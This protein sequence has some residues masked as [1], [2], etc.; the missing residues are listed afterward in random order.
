MRAGDQS[1]DLLGRRSNRRVGCGRC[2]CGL[3]FGCLGVGWFRLRS[4][5]HCRG[6]LFRDD[7]CCGLRV[8]GDGVG[9]AGAGVGAAGAGVGAAGA[10]VGAAGA[11]VRAAGAGVVAAGCSGVD[12]FSDAGP[13]SPLVGFSLVMRLPPLDRAQRDRI[14]LGGR[15]PRTPPRIPPCRVRM[16]AA[17]RRR[18]AG[19]GR[20]SWHSRCK[21]RPC[22][23]LPTRRPDIRA[24]RLRVGRRADNARRS[25]TTQHA[26][27]SRN[28]L[29]SA[30]RAAIG[31]PGSPS[32]SSST[33]PLSV[34]MTWPRWKS[35]CT[36]CSGTG[37]C[38]AR[39]RRTRGDRRGVSRQFGT[40]ICAARVATHRLGHRFKTAGRPL[41]SVAPGPSPNARLRWPSPPL[42]F[43][44]ESPRPRR[45]AGH[46]RRTGRARW[47]PPVPSRR[48]LSA[49][50]PGAAQGARVPSTSLSIQPC[51]AGTCM[52]THLGKGASHLEVGIESRHHDAEQ[53]HDGLLAEHDRRVRLL[54][55]EHQAD[56]VGIEFGA[57]LKGERISLRV[58][59]LAT[60]PSIVCIRSWSWLASYTHPCRRR[61]R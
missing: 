5:R 41:R 21:T 49:R 12:G 46:L 61:G 25:R 30:V 18:R 24:A 19:H 26:A 51:S 14:Q 7:G 10:G 33:Q 28:G 16:R 13:A 59:S 54:A 36:R 1:V 2:G 38:S 40:A 56:G 22:C 29:E 42:R 55:A 45:R 15:E 8:T 60:Q 27:T 37:R 58:S 53:L 35:P 43:G 11:G 31:A 44:R 32:K 17:R 57:G 20:R 48:C 6:T 34:R 47:S 52:V 50:I 23:A 3:R 9:A 4:A 39:V